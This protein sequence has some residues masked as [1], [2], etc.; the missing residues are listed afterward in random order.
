MHELLNC[1]HV[2]TLTGGIDGVKGNCGVAVWKK[3]LHFAEYFS[4]M[5]ND[6]GRPGY[7][8]GHQVRVMCKHVAKD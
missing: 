3:L 8:P 7:I 4:G 5:G 6:L 1:C 2:R